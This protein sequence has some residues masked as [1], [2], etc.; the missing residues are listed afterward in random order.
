[1]AP[2][3]LQQRERPVG[4]RLGD[5]PAYF[6]ARGLEVGG[7]GLGFGGRGKIRTAYFEFAL[8]YSR[9]I[10]MAAVYLTEEDVAGL[11]DMPLAV[12]A[13]NEA[14]GALGRAE[15]E[16]VPR[17]RAKAPGVVLH[18]MSAAAGYLGVVGWKNYTTTRSGAKFL[19]GLHAAESGELLALIE[20]DR[21]GQYRTGA[22]TG[23]AIQ[24][25]TFDEENSLGLFGSGWQ[26]ETQLLAACTARTI[27]DVAV[28]SRSA[29]R[30][31]EFAARMEREL[32]EKLGRAI[33]VRAV[34]DAAEAA[35]MP[36]VITATS[37]KEP[38]FAAESLA[39]DVLVCA[40]GSNWPNKA[41]VS[42]EVVE[43]VKVVVCDQVATCRI[44][45]GELIQAASAGQF[46]WAR[47]V[48]LGDVVTGKTAVEN[49]G[50]RMFKSVG[51]AIEDVALGFR[52]LELARERGV[53]RALPF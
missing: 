16:N 42:A 14:F 44:E 32:A 38:V 31:V 17:A 26:A 40:A 3:L 10:V 41:E 30:R 46:D 2:F 21:L 52:L 20:A 50:V 48:A 4:R 36:V 29:E 37:S 15:A 39:D 25:L 8:S 49:R 19:V 53:G 34:D 33:R 23:V 11:V 51:L 12:S 13:V 22:A 6:F 27:R 28:F 43:R 18:C 7:W 24:Q 45:A 5:Q 9:V 47:A 1:V 35:N